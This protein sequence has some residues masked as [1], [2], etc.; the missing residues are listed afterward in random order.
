MVPGA[1][2]NTSNAALDALKEF[3]DQHNLPNPEVLRVNW[4]VSATV[5]GFVLRASLADPRPAV[6][7]S[8]ACRDAGIA[9]ME[10]K[11]SP[12]QH[13]NWWVTGWQWLA[14]ARP[15]TLC[16]V[17]TLAA[18]LERCPASQGLRPIEPMVWV[19]DYL[20]RAKGQLTNDLV[21]VYGRVDRMR[22]AAQVLWDVIATS[23]SVLVHGDL[24]IDN[25]VCTPT[26]TM[27]DADG[28]GS[29]PAGWDLVRVAGARYWG[30]DADTA[31]T[32]W[33][34]YKQVGGTLAI[35][36]IEPLISIFLLRRICWRLWRATEVTAGSPECVALVASVVEQLSELELRL[37]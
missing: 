8:A 23:D 26:P 4:E 27:V 13:G 24:S 7:F 5:P 10:A 37:S 35:A 3:A 22:T 30:V 11:I 2:N 19:D 29:G 34:T 21:E 15:S 25:I 28:F 12:R 33:V 36:D 31:N 6:A 32:A 18:Q 14:A 1:E 20:G 16:D 9:V 17:A